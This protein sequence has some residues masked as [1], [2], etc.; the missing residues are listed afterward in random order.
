M[1][2]LVRV[3]V[4]RDS[5]FTVTEVVTALAIMGLIFMVVIRGYLTSA[6]RAEWSAYSL[7]AQSLADQGIEQA[8][9]ARWEPQTYPVVDELGV[10]NYMQVERIDL[11]DS[12][13]PVYAT[14]YISITSVSANPPL[15]QLRAD[16]V[17]LLASRGNK[18]RGPFTNTA[19]CLRASDQ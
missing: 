8:R 19:I 14:N 2:G 17:W 4:R 15:R 13:N 10:T 3:P 11:A 18:I 9:A 16:C 5:A 1:A 12:A 7:A 6:D